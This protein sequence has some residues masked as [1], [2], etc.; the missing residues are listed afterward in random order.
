PDG[1]HA[2]VVEP[3]R[4]VIVELQGATQVAE[5]GVATEYEQTDVA[6]VGAPPRVLVLSRRATH[7]TVHLI[8]LD[9]PRARAEIQI[10]STMRLGATVGSHALVIGATSTAVL[11]AGEA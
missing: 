6:W 10:E 5:L 7:S 1:S 9:G 11:T 4:V 3:G 2:A 8:D